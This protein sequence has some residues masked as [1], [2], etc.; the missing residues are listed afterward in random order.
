MV[1]AM[2]YVYLFYSLLNLCTATSECG[3]TQCHSLC[4]LV[5]SST[6]HVASETDVYTC[7]EETCRTH[8]F[9]DE[10]VE[11]A[12]PMF[13]DGVTQLHEKWLRRGHGTLEPFNR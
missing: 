9:L 5:N 7:L 12:P 13:H 4:S 3:L 1:I 2:D 10:L 6:L 8:V 11:H